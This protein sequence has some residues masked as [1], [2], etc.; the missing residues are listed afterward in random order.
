MGDSNPFSILGDVR[1]KEIPQPIRFAVG[2]HFRGLKASLRR[3]DL[4]LHGLTPRGANL[5]TSILRRSSHS[6]L[7]YTLARQQAWL[8]W[9]FRPIFQEILK[10][11]PSQGFRSVTQKPM[12][13]AN[14][15]L[16]KGELFR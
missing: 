15:A 3:F 1:A 11:L 12:G 4:A 2:R 14:R 9:C 7:V 6:L 13:I 8:W 10:G 5:D 16:F